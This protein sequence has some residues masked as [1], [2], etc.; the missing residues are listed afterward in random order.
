MLK[1]CKKGIDKRFCL[2]YNCSTS[3]EEVF[4]ACRF[5]ANNLPATLRMR[6]V[7]TTKIFQIGGAVT[8]G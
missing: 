5:C 7:H 1:K 8:H 6:E 2:W 4:F 3:A